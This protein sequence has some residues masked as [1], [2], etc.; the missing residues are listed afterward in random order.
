[1][2]VYNFLEAVNSGR[3]FKPVNQD[4]HGWLEVKEEEEGGDRYIYW[5]GKIQN[6]PVGY[7]NDE[8]I[9]EDREI[10]IS[11][12]KFDS[13]YHLWVESLVNFDMVDHRLGM[14]KDMGFYDE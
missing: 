11:E 7:I 10:T 9:L 14:K 12:S 5:E 2:K 4:D 3:R 13:L 1:M 6:L 8:Y